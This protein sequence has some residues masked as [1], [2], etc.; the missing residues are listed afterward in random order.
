MFFLLHIHLLCTTLYTIFYII[1][2]N[3]FHLINSYRI[4]LHIFDF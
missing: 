2:F 3:C 4:V 1:F